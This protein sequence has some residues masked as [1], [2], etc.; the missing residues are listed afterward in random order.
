MHNQI[1]ESRRIFT[2]EHDE[3]EKCLSLSINAVS[4]FFLNG[5]RQ[6]RAPFCR[7]SSAKDRD[8]KEVY[9]EEVENGETEWMV[10]TRTSCVRT[11]KGVVKGAKN[12]DSICIQYWFQSDIVDSNF[13]DLLLTTQERKLSAYV[14]KD[15]AFRKST[16]MH[17]DVIPVID[18]TLIRE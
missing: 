12:R 1:I 3:T 4:H 6:T 7:W 10:S 13:C 14:K 2:N 15:E 17:T 8:R 18:Q 5:T 11:S 9:Q 16:P